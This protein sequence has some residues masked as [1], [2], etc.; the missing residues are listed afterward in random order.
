MERARSAK[1][2]SYGAPVTAD[3][4]KAIT[5]YLQRPFRQLSA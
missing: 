1:M 2:I 3:E 4:Q 5:G